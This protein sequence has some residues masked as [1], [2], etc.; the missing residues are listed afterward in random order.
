MSHL[1]SERVKSMCMNLRHAFF[2]SITC[3]SLSHQS[4]L[5]HYNMQCNV[6]SPGTDSTCL[7]LS[8]SPHSK[9]VCGAL[10]IDNRE[11]YHVN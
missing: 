7:F 11:K 5:L 8:V 2:Y 6:H 9:E 1:G 3:G 4:T 10:S